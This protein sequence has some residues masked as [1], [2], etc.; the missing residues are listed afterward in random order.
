[1]LRTMKIKK[2]IILN[3][4]RKCE[5]NPRSKGGRY[6]STELP[7]FA[8]FEG[9]TVT[10]YFIMGFIKIHRELKYALRILKGPTL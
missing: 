8:S 10:T 2:S 7:F 1:M 3:V 4:L 5:H 6:K 9:F